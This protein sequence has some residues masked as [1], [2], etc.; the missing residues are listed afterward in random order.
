VRVMSAEPRAL[1]L[2]M[3][4]ALVVGNTLGMS[5]FL[6]PAILAP[7]G[8]NAL[9]AWLVTAGG[10]LCVAWVFAGMARSFP[11]DDGPYAY[12]ARAFGSQVAFVTLWCYWVAV[13]IGNAALAI[14]VVGYLAVFFPLLNVHRWLAAVTAVSLLWGFVLINLRGVRTAGWVQVITTA[15]KLLPQA[16][17]IAL[18]AWALLA[19]HATQAVHLPAT[20]ASL[21]AVLGASSIALFAMLGIECAAVPAGKVRDPGRTIPRAT[22]A[23]TLIV[24]L[25]YLCI[26]G[27]P[28]L[29]IPQAQLAASSAPFADLFARFLGD[30]YG[31][32]LAAFVIISGLG[33]LN[34]WTLVAGEI[35]QSCARHGGFPAALGKV[36][37][38]GAPARAFILTGIIASV[39]VLMNYDESMAGAFT[40]LIVIS[41]AANLPMYLACSLAVLVLWRREQIPQPGPRELRWFAA[42]LLATLYCVWIFIGIG[43]KP[44][45]WA[46]AL[47]C[48]G[49]PVYWWYARMRPATLAA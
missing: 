25:I 22:F 43:A 49:V 21:A 35:T 10:C 44:L 26:S 19:R 31:K 4:T 40:L 11:G 9:T 32:L 45:L 5:I 13:W 34:G 41:T 12:A 15:L 24:A 23:G 17:I 27:V 39:M 48:A 47:S 33:T 30:G 28:M 29:L 46:L 1:G 3:C 8:L 7:Y 20:P 6:L 2:L 16:G 42:A 14:A 37:S 36:N 38:R 18:G